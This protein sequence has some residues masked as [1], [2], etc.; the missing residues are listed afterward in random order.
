MRQYKIA[1]GNMVVTVFIMSLNMLKSSLYYRKQ[2]VYIQLWTCIVNFRCVG[3]FQT[4]TM[5]QA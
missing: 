1:Y 2:W 4:Y 3:L 5:I